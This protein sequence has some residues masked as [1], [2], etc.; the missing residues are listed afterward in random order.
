MLGVFALLLLSVLLALK[1]CSGKSSSDWSLPEN[2]FAFLQEREQLPGT[3]RTVTASLDSMGTSHNITEFFMLGLSEKPEVQRTLF[4][5]FLIIYVATVGGNVLIVV[6]LTS[7]STLATPMYFFL[8]NLSFI[9]TCYSSSLAPKLI[10]D[11]LYQGTTISYEGCMA[12][13][14][15]AHFLEALR[16]SCSL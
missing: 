12:Q 6:T 9:D 5:V 2:V 13:L 14:F 1:F 10:A 8:A 7:S 4:V 11:S 16:S 3:G 15:G